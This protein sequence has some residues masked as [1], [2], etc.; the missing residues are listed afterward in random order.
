ML[1]KNFYS[2]HT[3]PNYAWLGRNKKFMKVYS[4]Y[5][6]DTEKKTIAGFVYDLEQSLGQFK[7][8]VLTNTI[9]Y[10]NYSY[11]LEVAAAALTDG[12]ESIS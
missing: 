7:Y 2:T 9:E 8:N 5:S 11:P 10:Y 12:K 3:Y 6:N 4:Y 1:G